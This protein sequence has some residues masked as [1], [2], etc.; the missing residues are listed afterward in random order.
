MHFIKETDLEWLSLNYRKERAA[1]ICQSRRRM[2]LIMFQR[3][4]SYF[5]SLRDIRNE[6]IMG[7]LNILKQKSQR[8]TNAV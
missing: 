2:I 6:L 7:Q 1:S 4:I 8:W 5:P 3:D